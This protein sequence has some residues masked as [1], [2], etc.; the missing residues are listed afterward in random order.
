MEFL[1]DIIVASEGSP[2]VLLVVDAK[3]T[4]GDLDQAVRQLKR[5]MVGMS[6]PGGLLVSPDEITI[7]RNQYRGPDEGSVELVGAY[8]ITA[9]FRP[10]RSEFDFE[11]AVQEW[12]EHLAF[13]GAARGLSPELCNALEEHVIP[14]LQQGEVR[15]A[16]P[17]EAR[18]A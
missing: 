2:R 12:L 14:L 13:T 4:R 8:P 9:V 1:P 16:H 5:Y 10:A 6:C 17:R 15:A 3:L 7:F 18:R 11:R